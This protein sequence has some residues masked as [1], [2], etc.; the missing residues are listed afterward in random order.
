M[1]ETE[2]GK[3]MALMLVLMNLLILTAVGGLVWI[4]QTI[5]ANANHL[6]SLANR[7]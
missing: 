3:M 7:F 4:A 1:R 6:N 2:T 5:I